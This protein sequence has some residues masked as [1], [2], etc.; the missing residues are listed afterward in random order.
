MKI[1]KDMALIAAG[2][3]MLCAYQKYS[4]PVMKKM[5]KVVD[6]TMDSMNEKLDNMV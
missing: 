3:G 4:K 5:K 2:M 6:K 1:A